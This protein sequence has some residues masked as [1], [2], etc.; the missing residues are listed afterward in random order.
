[1][2]TERLVS[3]PGLKTLSELLCELDGQAA[4][5]LEPAEITERALAGSDR[6]CAEALAMFC[7]ILGTA[8]ANLAA[9]LGARGGVYIGGGIVPKLGSYFAR[10]AFR[11]RFE[12]KGRFRAYVSA[13][14][15]YVILAETLALRGLASVLDGGE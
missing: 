11:A 1:M 13:I 12:D 7:A 9:V 14:P 6:H 4:T 3:G 8:A 15:T 10:S 2:S 5:P